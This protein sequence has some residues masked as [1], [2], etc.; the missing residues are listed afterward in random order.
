M[1][2]LRYS[3][4]I[5]LVLA[6]GIW[7]FQAAPQKKEARV[8]QVIKDVRL[9]TSQGAPRP[10]SVNDSVNEGSAVRTG[11][12]SRAE[13]TFNDLTLTRLGANTVFS[14]SANGR[15]VELTGGAILLA[16]P[17]NT[18]TT[19]VK[20]GVATAAVSGFA[21]L[22]ETHLNSQSKIVLLDGNG[23]VSIKNV[24]D[25]C[26][27]HSGQM[28]VIPLHPTTCPP[29][30]NI[31]LTK[32]VQTAKLITIWPLPAWVL[33]PILEHADK[34][35][36]SDP[37]GGYT[38]PTSLNPTDQHIDTRPPPTPIPQPTFVGC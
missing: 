24:S 38:D 1:K 11:D 35:K 14:F 8:T 33:D 9:L 28:M 10:A 15:D 19:K 4:L 26:A 25:P 31:D 12:E 6:L 3:P 29:V 34:Q 23:V 22:F 20:M 7:R 5:L 2:P 17:E 32:Q 16:A 30:Y 27:I 13:I 36:G 18:G 37:D 21:G